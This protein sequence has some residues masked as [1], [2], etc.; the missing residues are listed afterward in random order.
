MYSIKKE[1]YIYIIILLVL[2][3]VSFGLGYFLF[4]TDNLKETKAIPI[5]D[6]ISLNVMPIISEDVVVKSNYVGYVEAINQVSIIPY[7]SGYLQN[8]PIKAGQYV[9]RGDLLV[10]INPDEYKAKLDSTTANVLQ[11]QASFEYNKS[12][13]DRVKKSGKNTFSETEIDN[14]KN[15][16]LQAQALLKNAEANRNFAQIN[17]NY[18]TINAPIS[19]LIGN[20][21][22]SIGDYVSPSSNPLLTIMQIDPIRVVFSL[23][24]TEYLNMKK[25]GHLFK[26]SV[27]KLKLSNGENYEYAGEFKYTDNKINKQTNSLAI[28]VYFKNNK[29]QLFPN[30]F[31]T[32][33]VNKTFKNIVS[34]DKNFIKIKNNG[35]FITIA[36]DNK[37][38]EIPIKIISDK[39]NQYLL[40][41][42]FKLGD[43]IVLDDINNLSTNKK[44]S[45]NIIK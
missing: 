34:I 26:D 19:G 11:A 28:Y 6:S 36:R 9:N 38:E 10:T 40:E 21:N 12:Y 3:L 44:I 4:S 39:D 15:N 25:D 43:M 14:A 8:I 5:N 45:F 2:C 18:T 13:Y 23:T 29:Q 37:I 24:D 27:I 31:V 35:Y 16:Y 1:R 22:L 7:I 17:Y 32:V 33:E 41:N 30:A 42:T 20:F